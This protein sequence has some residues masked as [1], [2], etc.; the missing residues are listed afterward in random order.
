VEQTPDLK[1]P[2]AVLRAELLDCFE[3]RK[4]GQYVILCYYI[5]TSDACAI[6]TSGASPRITDPETKERDRTKPRMEVEV[7]VNLVDSI[8]GSLTRS[9]MEN[10][11]SLGKN[12]TGGKAT[13]EQTDAQ[14]AMMVGTDNTAK[15]VAKEKEKAKHLIR[16][17]AKGK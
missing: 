8:T 17:V 12:D 7:A 1:I 9:T 10:T 13:V 3:C 6:E 14:L 15:V 5:C 11:S 2:S 4:S 16:S